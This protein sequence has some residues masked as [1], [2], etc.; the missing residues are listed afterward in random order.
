[1]STKAE[2][3]AS[4]LSVA[5]EAMVWCLEYFARLDESN[6][7]IHCAPVRYSP[8]TFRCERALIE[9]GVDRSEHPVLAE[10]YAHDGAYEEDKGR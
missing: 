4:A 7:K 10:V 1:M 8:I 2:R 3:A 5:I 9:L 6:A